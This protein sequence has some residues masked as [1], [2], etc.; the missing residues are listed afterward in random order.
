MMALDAWCARWRI[1]HQALVELLT[2]DG[3]LT[4]GDS[5]SESGVQSRIRLDAPKFGVTL[6]RNNSGAAVDDTG[7]HIRYGLGNDSKRVNES[8]K[9]SDL[10]GINHVGRFVAVECKAP[11]WKF[12]QNDERAVAQA[13]FLAH[14]R[15][16]G[17]IAGFCQSLEDFHALVR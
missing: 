10:I 16:S 4:S 1:P 6:W 9:S 13:R 15:A 17:G 11:G 3:G 8:F 7:R 12:S 5:V 14:V 2:S